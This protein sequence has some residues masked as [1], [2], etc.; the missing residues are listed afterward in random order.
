MGS[1]G[2]LLLGGT[3][4][5]GTYICNALRSVSA[6]CVSVGFRDFNLVEQKDVRALYKGL[7]PTVVVHAAAACGGT[8]ANLANEL[9]L[10]AVK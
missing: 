7:Q 1:A 3:G 8:G 6:T 5:F 10:E 4:L 9:G 2:L